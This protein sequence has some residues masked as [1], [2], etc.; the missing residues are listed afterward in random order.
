MKIKL[1]NSI[2]KQKNQ[3]IH[4]QKYYK[5]KNTVNKHESIR[6]LI[7]KNIDDR[8]WPTQATL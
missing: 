7:I 1:D 6:D 2:N 8:F 5:S 3:K 4:K